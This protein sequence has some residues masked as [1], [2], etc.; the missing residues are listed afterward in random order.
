MTEAIRRAMWALVLCT[1]IPASV[2]RAQADAKDWPMY[3][4]DVIGTRHNPGETAIGP[5]DA[6]RLE[7]KWRFPAKGSDQEIGV[8]HATPI[9]VDGYVYFGTATDPT[10]YKLS[11][12]GKVRW[13][14]RRNPARAGG[15]AASGSGK[16]DAR[17]RSLRFQSS[18]DGIMGSALVTEDTVYFGDVGG[19]FYALDRA[20]GAERWK[21]NARAK[22]FPGA[23]PINVFMASP[24][25]VEGKLIVAGG[26]LEQLLAGGLFYRGSTGR[27]FVMALEPKTGRIAWKY[28]VGPKPEPLNPPI[29]IKDSWG[30]HIFYFGP[31]TSSV[32]C[33]PSYDAESRTIF[34]GTDV[35]TAPRR[36]T[37]DDPRLY[38]RD[39]CAI[40]A[41]DVRDG[42]EK[43]VTQLNPGDV[44]T[45]SMRAYDPKEGRYKDQSIGDTPKVYTIAVEGKP[46]R[47]VGVGCKNGGFYVLRASDGK[48]L[49]HTPLYTGPPTYPLSPTPDRRMLALPSCI[50]GL[51]TGCATDGESIFT[52]GIDAIRLAGP[53]ARRR[54]SPSARAADGRSR[55]R[56]HHRHPD[57]ALAARTPQGRLARR[58]GAEAGIHRTSG[59]PVASGI[60][61][62]NGASSTSPRLPAA[63]WS[64]STRQ[65][66]RSS[67]SS[68]W[69]RS[70]RGP[71]SRAGASTSARATPCSAPPTPRH[72]SP[73]RTRA[74]FTPS[75]SPARTKS[76]ALA[77]GEG[78]V[79]RVGNEI[80]PCY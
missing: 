10:F 79:A 47:V 26:T 67:R 14:Y 12:D 9:V 34:F 62:A 60:A 80:P 57:R 78:S 42:A 76:A 15:Q 40:I 30:D 46:T 58:A 18:P 54:R 1:A 72:S 2:A 29:T 55:G 74:F 63:S 39:S 70:G 43:W 28:D 50:G 71:R 69:D 37:T 68:T 59:D 7:E 4:H 27:G 52:N 3:N 66:V 64:R 73:R 48:T 61:V 23:H 56:H 17:S 8:I 20:T 25:L 32:W 11:P 19:W 33:T 22:E 5:G 49:D 65:P 13:S 38:T 35:N 24:I 51:Q 41:V 77:G 36:P 45:N 16:S 6:G 31:G 44:W 21:L 75:A 53:L